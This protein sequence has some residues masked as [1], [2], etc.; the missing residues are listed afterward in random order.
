TVPTWG[1]RPDGKLLIQQWSASKA[2][3]ESSA[4]GARGLAMATDDKLLAQEKACPRIERDRDRLVVITTARGDQGARQ[5]GQDAVLGDPHDN[6]AP[7]RQTVRTGQGKRCR[8]GS[9]HKRRAALYVNRQSQIVPA[10]RTGRSGR[11]S[12]PDG[13]PAGKLPGTRRLGAIRV[14]RAQHKRWV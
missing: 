10:D 6:L 5:P 12:D 9:Q 7:G 4:N 8:H 1:T 13:H 3:P 2:D 11:K 14:R